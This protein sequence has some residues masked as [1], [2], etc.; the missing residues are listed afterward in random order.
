MNKTTKEQFHI[1]DE[2]GRWIGYSITVGIC[3]CNYL[4]KDGTEKKVKFFASTW[5]TRDGE[6]FGAIQKKIY[7]NDIVEVSKLAVE[8]MERSRRAMWKKFGGAQ[9]S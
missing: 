1:R 6:Y 2:K 4:T 5:V 9:C 3:D 7:A 8:R